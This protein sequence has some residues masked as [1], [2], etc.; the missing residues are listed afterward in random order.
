MKKPRPQRQP[1]KPRRP[2]IYLDL[3]VVCEGFRPGTMAVL[4]ASGTTQI[5]ELTEAEINGIR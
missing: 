3:E 4:C 1:K 5:I 2:P